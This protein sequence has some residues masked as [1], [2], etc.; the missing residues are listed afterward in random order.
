MN[1]YSL[2]IKTHKKTGLK[3]LCQT[4]KDP[5]KYNGSGIDWKLHL[6]EHGRE[7]TTEVLVQTSSWDE[8]STYGRY[9]SV[10]YNIVG[11]MDDFG[12]KIWANRIIECGGGGGA[13]FGDKNP[14]R[15]TSGKNKFIAVI[16]TPENKKLKSE[17]TK[18]SWD[19][20]SIR[21]HRVAEIKKSLSSPIS[22]Q[23]QRTAASQRADDRLK[24]A[25]HNFQGSNNSRFDPTIYCFRNIK[26]EETVYSTKLDFVKKYLSGKYGHIDKVVSGKRK[27]HLG[28]VIV[29]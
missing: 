11:S 23:R 15:S 28:W 12:N 27:T 26:T 29:R 18:K 3:Y 16:N 21:E 24:N 1:I 25:T 22:K 17:N 20:P 2:V 9:Y 4:T 6:K 5:F 13:A 7:H 10:Y 19:E 8:L 14:M